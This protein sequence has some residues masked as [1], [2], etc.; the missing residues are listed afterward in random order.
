M[1]ARRFVTLMGRSSGDLWSQSL[2][3]LT[4]FSLGWLLLEKD[5]ID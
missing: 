5:S 1:I 2:P 3:R 4:F